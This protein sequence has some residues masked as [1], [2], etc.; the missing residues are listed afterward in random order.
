MMYYLNPKRAIGYMVGIIAI[1]IISPLA[2]G[3][4]PFGLQDALIRGVQQTITLLSGGGAEGV[5]SEIFGADLVLPD[6]VLF[7]VGISPERIA[8]YSGIDSGYIQC[9]WRYGGWG[10]LLLFGAF[11][12]CFVTTYKSTGVKMYRVI[13]ACIAI[14]FFVYLFKLYSLSSYANNF[15]IFSVLTFIILDSGLERKRERGG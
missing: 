4:L 15:L 7:G 14:I 5:Y 8:G 11:I 12:Y 3:K 6:D 1:F 2:F 9:I 10:S 13:V